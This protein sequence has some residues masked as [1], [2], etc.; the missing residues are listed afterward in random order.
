MTDNNSA[1]RTA[2]LLARPLMRPYVYDIVWFVLGD[3]QFKATKNFPFSDFT[4]KRRIKDMNCDVECELMKR[5]QDRVLRW[6]LIH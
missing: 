3:N 5:I 6:K 1:Q 2:A 4:V